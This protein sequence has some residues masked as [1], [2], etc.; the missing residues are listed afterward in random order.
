MQRAH[1]ASRSASNAKRDFDY[2]RF[3]TLAGELG[4]PPEGDYRVAFRRLG[5]WRPVR[6]LLL[7]TFALIF[8]G[9]FLIWL[10][11]PEHWPHD[12]SRAMQIASDVMVANTGI[13]GLLALINVTTLCRASLAARDPVPVRHEPGLRVAFLTTIVPA[14]EPLAM[15]RKTLEAA[16]EIR[17]DGPFDVWLL[18]EGGD[19]GVPAMC[20]ELGVNH[21]SRQ[22]I[23]R[24]N[25]PS[26]RFR[27]K[28]KHGNY[29]S[30][31]EAHGGDY[32]VMISV[33]PDHVPFPC[34]CERFLGYFRDPDV[35]FVIGPQVYGN[36]RGFVAR[37]AESQQFLFHSLLQRA[38]NRSRTPMLVGTNNA[39]RISALKAAGGFQDS[40]T[41]DMAT[42]LQ[43]HTRRNRETG[44][45]WSS[46]YTP[47][48]IAV[49]E[50]PETF[51]DY[52]SQQ[53]RWS[54][55][56]DDVLFTRFW[57]QARRLSPRQ[58]VHY[59][60]LMSYYPTTA[61]AWTLGVLNGLLYLTL[62]AGGVTVPMHL[63]LMLYV[64]AAALQIGLYFWNRR[65][66]VSPHE[67]Q[68]SSGI[69]GMFISTL[70]TPIYV[71][72]LTATVLRRRRGFV[73]TAKGGAQGADSLATFAIHLRW[74]GLIALPLTV[75][76]ALG[77]IA[78]PW[79]YL[80]TVLGLLVC[81]VPVAIW[82]LERSGAPAPPSRM[83][84]LDRASRR[85]IGADA[86]ARRPRPEPVLEKAAFGERIE[87][88]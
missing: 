74:A 79:M 75:S 9:G 17:H 47:D 58:V 12:A 42:S 78:D 26:G 46:V 22:G 84:R 49:G 36:Y 31:L 32:D 69:S 25:R 6:T 88:A 20:R 54:R 8:V 45:R 10:M 67:R 81:L 82:R 23:S 66:N 3:S 18:D 24:W 27:A 70:S 44:R 15:V 37:A 57:R 16:L 48:L 13:I 11:L 30:W 86:R 61:I 50:G 80:W 28:S 83:R 64:D 35:A 53:Y 29:N 19:P 77:N 59:T 40:I 41:E 33:D 72:S 43:I 56:T 52:F 1:G 85:R 51:T 5:Y 60:L 87:A 21:F 62:H 39:I 7:V 76:L 4:E 55:G 71:A 73:V 34:F 63:W 38:G 65:H 68:G 2:D 14:R